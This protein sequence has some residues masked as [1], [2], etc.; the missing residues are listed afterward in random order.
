M[1]NEFGG[2]REDFI[3]RLFD[4]IKE[5][6]SNV[7]NTIS[8]QTDAIESLSSVVKEGVKNEELKEIIVN[9]VE[10]SNSKIDKLMNRVGIMIACISI[11]FSISAISYFIV[12]SSVDTMINKKMNQHSVIM[13][14]DQK[15]MNLDYE[16]FEDRIN[17]I[18]E[19]MEKLHGE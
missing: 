12:R 14:D 7:I 18:I 11:A 15:S 1:S 9:H 19:T 5:S 10:L 13:K 6:N 17:K 3:L 16:R 4:T 2:M 8:K